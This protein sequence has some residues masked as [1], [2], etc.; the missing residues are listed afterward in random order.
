[1]NKNSKQNN[2]TFAYRSGKQEKIKHEFS[3]RE[4]KNLFCG[5]KQSVCILRERIAPLSVNGVF[6]SS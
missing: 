5:Q 3:F 4:I 2:V 6:Y 1:M